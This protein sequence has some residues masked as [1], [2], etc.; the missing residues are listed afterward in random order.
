MSFPKSTLFTELDWNFRHKVQATDATEGSIPINDSDLGALAFSWKAD[1]L[2]LFKNAFYSQAG[3]VLEANGTGK[4]HKNPELATYRLPMLIPA[5]YTFEF[6]LAIPKDLPK[7]FDNSAISVDGRDDRIFVGAVNGQGYTAGFLFTRN[8]IGVC[9]SPYSDP[10]DVTILQGSEDYLF[11]ADGEFV[12]AVSVRATVNHDTGVMNVYVTSTSDAYSKDFTYGDHVLRYTINAPASTLGSLSAG[13]LGEENVGLQRTDQILVAVRSPSIPKSEA[14]GDT[15]SPF[16]SEWTNVT[17]HE[18]HYY[19]EVSS[20]RL[21]S[22]VMEVPDKPLA[23]IPFADQAVIGRKFKLDG[24]AST[25][26]LGNPLTYH[27][28]CIEKP[29]GSV[30]LLKGGYAPT[31]TIGTEEADNQLALTY[32]RTGMEGNG[33]RITIVT[34]ADGGPLL[35]EPISSGETKVTLATTANGAVL[36]SASELRSAINT[37]SPPISD[38]PTNLVKPLLVKASVVGEG[39]GMVTPGI[40]SLSS[41]GKGSTKAVTYV[42]FDIPGMYRFSLQVSNATRDS[43]PKILTVNAV[44]DDVLFNHRPNS[45]YI[46]KSLPDFW[47]MVKDKSH[48][49][50]AWSAVTQVVSSEYLKVIQNDYSKSLEDISRKYQRRWLSH[51]MAYTMPYYLE[52]TLKPVQGSQVVLKPDAAAFTPGGSEVSFET[53]TRFATAWDL[54]NDQAL[55]PDPVEPNPVK[56]LVVGERCVVINSGGKI[57]PTGVLKT[58]YESGGTP[59]QIV[60]T[61]KALNAARIVDKGLFA[62]AVKIPADAG[63]PDAGTSLTNLVSLRGDTFASDVGVGDLLILKVGKSYS[64]EASKTGFICRQITAVDPQYAEGTPYVSV[65]EFDKTGPNLEDWRLQVTGNQHEWQIV[66]KTDF[67]QLMQY[68]YFDLSQVPQVDL[69]QNPFFFGDY[70]CITYRSAL[71]PEDELPAKLPI[72]HV[73]DSQIYVDW[74]PFFRDLNILAN[75]LL[76]QKKQG[77]LTVKTA[78]DAYGVNLPTKV[79]ND[80]NGDKVVIDVPGIMEIGLDKVWGDV[81]GAGGKVTNDDILV[82]DAFTF[83]SAPGLDL[84]ESVKL[85]SMHRCENI[86]VSSTVVGCPFL[87]ESTVYPDMQENKDYT[88]GGGLI[89]LYP[90]HQVRFKAIAGDTK[91]Y[92]SKSEYPIPLHK[93]SIDGQFSHWAGGPTP[94]QAVGLDCLT[95]TSGEIGTYGVVSVDQNATNVVLETTHRFRKSGEYYGRIP[96]WCFNGDYTPPERLWAE[97]T[98]FDN[99]ALIEKNFGAYVGLPKKY[100]DDNALELDYLTLVKS[101]W[102]AFLNGPTV[103]KMKVAAESFMG[104][105]FTQRRGLVSLITEA[106][107]SDMGR[108][109]VK[110]VEALYSDQNVIK[111]K[112][113]YSTYY[114]SDGFDLAINP[115]TGRRI[116]AASLKSAQ[117]NYMTVPQQLAVSALLADPDTPEK[118]KVYTFENDKFVFKEVVTKDYYTQ[119]LQAAYDVDD[120][121]IDANVGLVDA[122]D[123]FDYVSD[124]DKVNKFLLGKDQLTKFHTFFVHLPTKGLS[125]SNFQ[126]LLASYIKQWKPAYTDVL[127]V[128]IIELLDEIDVEEGWLAKPTLFLEDSPHT[129]QFKKEDLTKSAFKAQTGSSGMQPPWPTLTTVERNRVSGYLTTSNGVTTAVTTS[130]VADGIYDELELGQKIVVESDANTALQVQASPYIGNLEM[131]YIGGM[132]TQANGSVEITL[133]N[134][135]GGAV[136]YLGTPGHKKFWIMG[137]ILLDEGGDPYL[138]EQPLWAGRDSYDKYESSYVAGVL[139]DFSGD[140]S[141]NQERQLIDKVNSV[142]SDVDVVNTKL[143]VPIVVN[144]APNVGAPPFA[145]REFKVGEAVYLASGLQAGGVPVRIEGVGWD[146]LGT[147]INGAPPVIAHVGVGSHPKV[148]FGVINPQAAHPNTYLVLD[149]IQNGEE[150]YGNET[151]LRALQRIE[152]NTANL[153]VGEDSGAVAT[154]AGVRNTAAPY[155]TDWH[156]YP[157][158]D[159]AVDPS[160]PLH[161]KHKPYFIFEHVFSLDKLIETGPEISTRFLA[162]QYV[163]LGGTAL[164]DLD[165]MMGGI[166]P[167]GYYGSQL[168]QHPYNPDIPD[169]QQLVP[170]IGPGF[171]ANFNGVAGADKVEWGYEDEGIL[172]GTGVALTSFKPASDDGNYSMS[173]SPTSYIQNLHIPVAIM[174]DKNLQMSHGFTQTAIPA[175]KIETIELLPLDH[176]VRIE[177]HY[178]VAPDPTNTLPNG[179]DGTIGGGWVFFKHEI[180][181]TVYSAV[182]VDFKMGLEGADKTVLGRPGD[183]QTST[184][185]VLEAEIPGGLPDG[186]YHVIVRNYRPYK[187]THAGAT[188]LHVDE[189]IKEKAYLE[190]SMVPLPAP[191]GIPGDPEWGTGPWGGV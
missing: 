161:E 56:S 179:F 168:Q 164:Q 175:P 172:A 39:L 1:N 66:R 35:V 36:T 48:L 81:P 88:V 68:P 186:Y 63:V 166:A 189:S 146:D 80:V 123:V 138:K 159:I 137:E 108:I 8:G 145:E 41:D 23:V 184:G 30:A 54:A 141:W 71:S 46:W 47:G 5:S 121:I 11:N 136:G 52:G 14:I 183:L 83:K 15:S 135:A 109:V 94:E 101:L 118:S 132:Q 181:G 142:D 185:H 102:F 38:V 190:L 177:G 174:A 116:K 151:R 93:V 120:A 160:H 100:L 12:E 26:P 76:D 20:L 84:L 127:F 75:L 105:P 173:P 165:Q 2:F 87:G 22:G 64:A 25:D 134:A 16:K 19:V 152:D 60:L 148:P 124:S 70:V 67:A 178:F 77:L 82:S 98:Y 32:Y 129:A 122:V 112:L 31:V 4:I 62:V 7:S 72:L 149:F 180:Y 162:T 89:T 65:V 86:P 6:D 163:P 73:S 131:F 49:E 96:K 187:L 18:T 128:G 130:G 107:A 69:R 58:G 117:Q 110:D 28:E 3:L 59:G 176:K 167:L 97:L 143:W 92:I 99:S 61:T 113:G 57:G 44:L 24:R 33:H 21:A 45:D 95:V 103:D 10:D 79:I 53:L 119:K 125:E 106:T 156:V 144:N 104:F 90:R 158:Y 9:S 140:G 13:E 27:W 51:R 43:D 55:T 170:S 29:E 37:Y 17:T 50:V 154:I 42:E 169:D 139:D 91:V 115:R 191:D 114:Y 182:S 155:D 150:A 147:G 34:G 153:I 85:K 188:Q 78:K 157:N 40:Y 133:H 126:P 111:P 171:K 74:R